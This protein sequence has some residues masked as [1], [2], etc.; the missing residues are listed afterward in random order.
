MD[1]F[2]MLLKQ[3]YIML[4]PEMQAYTPSQPLVEVRDIVVRK[5]PILV[6]LLWHGRK[7]LPLGVCHLSS[8]WRKPSKCEEE[9]NYRKR[10]NQNIVFPVTL[11]LLT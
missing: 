6:K 1:L 8:G 4:S 7:S 9:Q 5:K 3:T 11:V 2:N 10:S